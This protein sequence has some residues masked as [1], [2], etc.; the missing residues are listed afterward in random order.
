MTASGQLC[1]SN[2]G[3]QIVLDIT[4]QYKLQQNNLYNFFLTYGLDY[5]SVIGLLAWS[6]VRDTCGEWDSDGFYYSRET[7]EQ[8]M[9][10]KMQNNFAG[11]NVDAGFLQL[12]NVDFPDSFQTAVRNVQ[13]N[14]QD[15]TQA[16]NERA[17]SVTN[18]TTEVLQA[19]QD[20]QVLL[21]Q[22]EADASVILATA[23]A[24]AQGIIATLS[25]QADVYF[26]I[27]NSLNLGPEDLINYISLQTIENSQ[28][29]VVGVESPAY[30]SFNSKS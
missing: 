24:T 12:S 25:A 13:E 19:E 4:Y 6:A 27:M 23:N 8:S 9:L 16:S 11:I 30:F 17:G 26:E 28:G 2:D 18:A 29:T 14:M 20:A 7:I 22:A 1:L 5:E 3:L 21:I 15:A 10:V